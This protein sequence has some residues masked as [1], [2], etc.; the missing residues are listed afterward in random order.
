M[1]MMS[2][3]AIIVNGFGRQKVYPPVGRCIYCGATNC[4]LGDEHILPQALGGN[5]ILRSAS[6]R[7]CERIVGGQL[8]GRLLEETTGMF[9]AMRLRS[10]FKSKRPKD[11]PDSLPYTVI[12][13]DGV[14]RIVNVPANKV[15]RHWITLLTEAPPGVIAGR[16]PHAHSQCTV[17][18]LYNPDDFAAF[19]Q[20]GETILFNG[21][22]EGKDLVRFL[23]K[24]A[25]A[26]VV[27]EKGIEA[28]EPWL[29]DFILGN[30][31]CTLDYYV[32]GYENKIADHKGDHSISIATWEDDGLRIGAAIRLFCKYGTPDY[33]VAVGK[34][35]KPDKQ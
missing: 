27:A 25:H 12:G 17:C 2:S 5:V 20:P 26:T 33:E 14:K 18:T 28:F 11:R 4:D 8:E 6:C 3:R 10:T 21:A 16:G 19:T 22:G 31:N 9:A 23:A 7:A 35:K 24:I 1:F 15:P 30:D 13:I 34:L 32:A 29:P